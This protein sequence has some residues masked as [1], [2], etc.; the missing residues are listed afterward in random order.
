MITDRCTLAPC[1]R[2]LVSCEQVDTLSHT[3]SVHSPARD[4]ALDTINRH[5]YDPTVSDSS[6]T[7]APRRATEASE[8]ERFIAMVEEGLADV[9]AGRVYTHAEVLAEM[10]ELFSGLEK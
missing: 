2:A 3:M 9:K 1:I 5:R 4:P 6:A 7:N 10:R 8:R